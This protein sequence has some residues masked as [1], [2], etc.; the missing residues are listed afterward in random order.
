[1]SNFSFRRPLDSFRRCTTKRVGLTAIVLFALIMFCMW[2]G[3]FKL[4]ILFL[5]VLLLVR[6]FIRFSTFRLS[7]GFAKR[8]L[9]NELN[10]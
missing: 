9:E 10:K 7:G 3:P 2:M 6:W 4:F 1:M 5:L 8:L